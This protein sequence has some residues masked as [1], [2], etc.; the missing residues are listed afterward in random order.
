MIFFSESDKVNLDSILIYIFIYVP[1]K[2]LI[3]VMFGLYSAYL[4]ATSMSNTI[5]CVLLLH[6]I[7]DLWDR[8]NYILARAGVF[9][10]IK[11]LKLL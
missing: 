3:F 1:Y 4:T 10:V 11:F 8:F 6:L 5:F 7:F 2:T 9:N